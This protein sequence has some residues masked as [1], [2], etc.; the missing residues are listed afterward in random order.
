MAAKYL[1]EEHAPH[2]I[3]VNY[4]SISAKKKANRLLHR[5]IT[6]ALLRV[7]FFCTKVL[8][9]AV[10]G[11]RKRVARQQ[12]WCDCFSKSP[13]TAGFRKFLTAS[14]FWHFAGPRK[15]NAAISA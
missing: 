7:S 6:L 8:P 3:I 5:R 1:P 12:I 4:L 9:A 14:L 10:T 2:R 13:A 15:I 11:F